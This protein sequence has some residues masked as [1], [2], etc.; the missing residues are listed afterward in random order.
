MSITI[1]EELILRRA[2]EAA[3]RLAK[4]VGTDEEIAEIEAAYSWYENQ[5][6]LPDDYAPYADM[7]MLDWCNKKRADAIKAN[8]G[9]SKWFTEQISEHG[10]E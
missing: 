2:L 3:K 7:Y 1:S 4:D 6:I 8:G 9:A 5:P 10:A